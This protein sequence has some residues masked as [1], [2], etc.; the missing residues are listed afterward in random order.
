MGS[1][2]RFA[3]P[4]RRLA[5]TQTARVNAALAPVIVARHLTWARIADRTGPVFA[6]DPTL[7]SADKF[8]P[9]A[10][11]YAVWVPVLNEAFDESPAKSAAKK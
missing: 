11:G 2:P 1:I 7:F 10:R 6:N 5:G 8:H 3:Q 9:N 4:L